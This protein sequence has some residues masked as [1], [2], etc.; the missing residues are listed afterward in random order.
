ME[1]NC[2][3]YSRTLANEAKAT[4]VV[5]R[6]HSI[7]WLHIKNHAIKLGYV[8]LKTCKFSDIS[9]IRPFNVLY[10]LVTKTRMCK[11]RLFWCTGAI[12]TGCL[13]RCHQWFIWM[14]AGIEPKFAR[15]KS[16]HWTMTAAY[17][18][19][20]KL[21]E[22]RLTVD[23]NVSASWVGFAVVGGRS[24]SVRP[25]IA[26]RRVVNSQ[27]TVHDA[28]IKLNWISVVPVTGALY[29]RNNLSWR[30]DYYWTNLHSSHQGK[31]ATR[32]N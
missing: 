9:E 2:C 23:L 28:I 31:R 15:W 16:S 18:Q 7:V 8:S 4:N 25:G 10:S 24:T 19:Y 30:F 14:T 12:L 17:W 27:L 22:N 6:T 3:Y 1:I 20:S 21:S 5:S 26:Q 32:N 29:N 11:A 13:L